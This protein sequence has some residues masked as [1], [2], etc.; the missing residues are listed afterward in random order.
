MILII[1]VYSDNVEALQT[2]VDHSNEDHQC[3][4]MENCQFIGDTLIKKVDWVLETL[5]TRMERL[6]TRLE[7][8]LEWLET[9]L[10]RL[11][12]I[13]ENLTNN[14]YIS[15]L[16][17][18][19]SDLSLESPSSTFVPEEFTMATEED[20]QEDTVDI[21]EMRGLKRQLTNTTRSLEAELVSATPHN[22]NVNTGDTTTLAQRNCPEKSAQP[23]RKLR[24]SY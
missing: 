4:L 23:A 9:R 22:S 21:N 12:S 19:I 3:E 5:E 7:T 17:A 24:K 10:G 14:F 2:A 15:E 6:E 11:E 16:N 13:S 1:V 20:Q 8:R 18:G